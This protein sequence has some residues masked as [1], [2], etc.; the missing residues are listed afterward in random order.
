MSDLRSISRSIEI[1]LPDESCIELDI[2]ITIKT[3]SNGAI[4][5]D[6]ISADSLGNVLEAIQIMLI[7]SLE[8]SQEEIEEMVGDD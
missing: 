1:F 7:T 6:R 3:E 5:N 2:N 8:N 4:A